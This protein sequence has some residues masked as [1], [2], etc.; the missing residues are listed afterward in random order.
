MKSNFPS[1]KP[2]DE[3]KTSIADQFPVTSEPAT[4]VNFKPLEPIQ[5]GSFVLL[6]VDHTE[7]VTEIVKIRQGFRVVKGFR[8]GFPCEV[9]EAKWCL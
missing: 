4:P 1:I 7:I 3:A 2:G 6:E 5:D 9:S 8:E